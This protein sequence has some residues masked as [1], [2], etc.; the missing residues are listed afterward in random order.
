MSFF[1]FFNSHG[2]P[3]PSPPIGCVSGW[4]EERAALPLVRPF[5]PEPYKEIGGG[6]RSQGAGL[7][8]QQVVI[9]TTI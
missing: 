3:G 8:S 4:Q 7:W 5:C 2:W 6:V 9:I 1:V